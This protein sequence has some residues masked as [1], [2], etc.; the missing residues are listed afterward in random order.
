MTETVAKTN[1][2]R[3]LVGAA[4]LIAAPAI[5]TG[6]AFAVTPEEIKKRGKLLVGIQGEDPP[7][8]F[9]DSSG[10][11][12]GF[13]ADIAE[14]FGKELGVP[15]EFTHL[16]VANRIPSLTT[17]RVDVLFA[18]MAML[19]ERAKVVQYSK[20]YVG[21]VIVLVGAK[22]DTIKSYADLK[23]FTIGV[24]SSST[25]DG[26]VT[27]NAPAGTTIRRFADDAATIQA[28]ISGQV[29][30]IGGNM[31]YLQRVEAS[32]PG[33]FEEKIEFT[34][35]FNGACTRQGEKELNAAL[36]TFIDKI[37]DNGQLAML[38]EKWLKRPMAELP[39]QIEGVPFTAN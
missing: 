11:Q 9:V 36:N 39:A 35:L 18:T 30:A 38:T 4:A 20:P 37:R 29:Q 28:L 34:R 23:K 25:Q 27:R 13:D 12:Q 22:S 10:K 19:P 32:K 24:P 21:N 14:L 17:G 3:L 26:A 1:R 8:G 15:V 31:F 7:F 5:L 33:V 16:A 6:A 2:R